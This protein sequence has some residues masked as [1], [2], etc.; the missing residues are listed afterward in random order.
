[1]AMEGID[2]ELFGQFWGLFRILQRSL[3]II[4]NIRVIQSNSAKSGMA[5]LT[6]PRSTRPAARTGR[7]FPRPVASL[8]MVLD[9]P[10]PPHPAKCYNI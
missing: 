10:E 8:G 2:F 4:T 7:V 5:K 3:E 1:M 6:R 9:P